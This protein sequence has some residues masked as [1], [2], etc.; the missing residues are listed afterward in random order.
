M[1]PRP[2]RDVSAIGRRRWLILAVGTFA[3]AATCAYLYG[4]TFVLP[5]LR[6]RFDTSL[7]GAATFVAAPA[8]GLVLTLVLWGAAADRYGERIVMGLGL[9]GA[10]VTLAV[11]AVFL[12]STVLLIGLVVAGAFGASVNAASGRVVLGWFSARE[13]GF[14]MGARQT[15]QPLGV[16]LASVTLPS[17][18]LTWGLGACLGFLAAV[19]LLAALGVAAFVADPPRPAR[20]GNGPAPSPYR[21]PVL[22]RLHAT[23]SLLVVP[24]IMA[25]T[26][27][28]DYLVSTRD[29][30]SVDAG[31]LIGI[32][33]LVG[34]TSRILVGIWSDRV[35][36]RMRPLR[37]VAVA[38]VVVTLLWWLGDVT[39]SAFAALALS[40]SLVVTV[41]GNGLG[42]TAVAE[43]AGPAWAGRALGIQNT[44]QNVV[45]FVVPPAFGGLIGV[46]SYAVALGVA[47]VFPLLAVVTTPVRGE[48]LE[49]L[50]PASPATPAE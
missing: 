3:Q 25:T 27:A 17:I 49:P 26:F 23:S 50:V 38:V 48:S 8:L 13:R 32:V 21:S 11:T 14:A 18:G 24:Q 7:A 12:G 34:A 43:R 16:G 47:A 31:H 40:A 6:D 19:C 35:G 9:T 39:G 36:S 15:A 5:T 28:L 45:A 1:S 44:A 29:W 41:T 2:D 20:A 37:L 4:L 22:W 10:A 33:Q 42:F 46:T 30:T